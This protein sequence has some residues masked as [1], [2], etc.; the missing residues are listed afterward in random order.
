MRPRSGG[1]DADP[2]Q[3]NNSMRSTSGLEGSCSSVL[4]ETSTKGLLPVFLKACADLGAAQVAVKH[5]TA[6][7]RVHLERPDFDLRGT[8]RP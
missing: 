4:K 7:V 5:R 1:D 6:R 8:H 2:A 3:L